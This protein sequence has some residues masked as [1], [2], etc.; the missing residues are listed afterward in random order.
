MFSPGF[1]CIHR[2]SFQVEAQSSIIAPSLDYTVNG[3]NLEYMISSYSSTISSSPTITSTGSELR[4]S[5]EQLQ[6]QQQY[7]RQNVGANSGLG[8]DRAVVAAGK[9]VPQ[10]SW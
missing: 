4:P 2:N 6:Q 5:T 10:M 3:N 9:E 7:T 1:R 8:T